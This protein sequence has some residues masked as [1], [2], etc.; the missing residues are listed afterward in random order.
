MQQAQAPT[1]D[2][3]PPPA[4]AR[5]FDECPDPQA[6]TPAEPVPVEP[7]PSEPVPSE[8]VVAGGGACGA[9]V[10]ICP[11]PQCCSQ[12]RTRGSQPCAGGELCP[13]WRGAPGRLISANLHLSLSLPQHGFCGETADHC[14][15]GCNAG[16]GR[17]A[18][19]S[20]KMKL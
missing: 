10:G 18:A 15:V 12:V 6:P 17:C 20:R 8:P 13:H 16:Y 14:G 2:A 4:P 11:D 3:L 1:P 5:S 19:G 9:G 7:V